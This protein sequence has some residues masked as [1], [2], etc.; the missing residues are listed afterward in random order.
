MFGVGRDLWGSSSP[1]PL[2]KQGH[3]EQAA[4]YHVQASFEYLLREG[5][6]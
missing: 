4:Q 1:S 6:H 2:L 5:Q 3:P